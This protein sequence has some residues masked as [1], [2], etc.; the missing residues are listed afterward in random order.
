MRILIAEDDEALARFVRQGLESEHYSV[1]VMPDGEQAR[2]AAT[3][4]EYDVVIL[5]LNLPKLDGVSVLRH[6]RSKKPSLPVL[7]LTQR[8]R[9][10]DRVQ[11]LDTGA[12]DY[13]AKPFSF[14][15]L[16]ARI[17]ALVR[18]SHLPSESVLVAADL[19]LDRVQRLVER[20]GRRI[21]LTGKE[22]LLLEYLMLNA[23]R[24]VTRSMIIEH[25]WNLT[26]DTTTNVVDVYI[27]YVETT[28]TLHIAFGEGIDYSVLY[29]IE[30]MMGC[31]TEACMA[32]PS[33]VRKNLQSI[34]RHRGESEVVFD[35]VADAGEF[36]RI[37]QSYC[38]RLAS[39]EI[40]LAGCGPFLWV[41]LLRSSRP[42]LDLLLR[43]PQADSV[44]G[45]PPAVLPRLPVPAPV[46]T[47]ET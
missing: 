32:V 45:F 11:C 13:L 4:F 10:E 21:E 9:V 46:P 44:G 15:E 8:T 6:L 19:R 30:Q 3:E 29:A 2:T 40:R 42:P 16:S 22:F 38:V 1:D 24:S 37:I 31:H 17:R 33:F 23:A 43:S 47:K 5:D 41:R 20:A 35:R 12:D 25:V 36:S 28:S 27:N 34:S 7:V 14:S 26:F 18:R 39:P